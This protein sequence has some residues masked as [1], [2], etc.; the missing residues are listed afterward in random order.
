VT[1]EPVTREQVK[2]FYD[3]VRKGKWKGREAEQAKEEA[4]LIRGVR[5][6]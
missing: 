2:T 4:R 1:P 3:D 6:A 5:A